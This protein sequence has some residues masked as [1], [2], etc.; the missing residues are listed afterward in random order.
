MLSIMENFQERDGSIAVPQ[1]LVEYGAPS[2]LGAERA[3]AS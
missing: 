3:P 1:P 2:R